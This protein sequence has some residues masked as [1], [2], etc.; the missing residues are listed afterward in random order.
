MQ[1][2][3]TKKNVYDNNMYVRITFKPF[4]SYIYMRKIHNIIYCLSINK[5]KTK[6]LIPTAFRFYIYIL[7]GTIN[8]QSYKSFII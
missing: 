2:I 7:N 1:Q 4:I 6:P 8:C 5:L 3:C